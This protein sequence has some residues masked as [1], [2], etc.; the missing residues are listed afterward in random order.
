MY[1]MINDIKGEKRIDLSYSIDSD[2]EI[3]VI[4]RFFSL[5]LRIT[6]Q[7]NDRN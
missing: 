2:K 6:D 3:A 5:T 4:I 7:N 1:I